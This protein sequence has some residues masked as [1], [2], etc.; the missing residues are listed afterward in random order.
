M[1]KK[2]RG[3]ALSEEIQGY[4]KDYIIEHGLKGGDALPSEGQLAEILGVSRSPVR[5]AVKALQ[6]LG[7]LEAKQG[8]GLF[9]REWNLDPLLETLNYGMRVS[10]RTLRELYQIR[11]WLENS[12]VSDIV[13]KVSDEELLELDILMLRWEKSMKS[14]KAYTQFDQE[15]HRI[16]L[17]ASGNETLVKLFEVFWIAFENYGDKTILVSDD[18]DRILREHKDVLEALRKR[19]PELVRK[20]LLVHFEGFRDRVD[21]LVEKDLP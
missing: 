9:V 5:E 14:G 1:Q 19:D 10:I 20:M 15:F 7:I 17:G 4:V 16:L 6:S 13:E 2:L 12:I 21:L 3:P 11:T 18:H 8:E